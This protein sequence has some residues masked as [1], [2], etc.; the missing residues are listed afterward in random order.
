VERAEFTEII[1]EDE[2]ASMEEQRETDSVP[3]VDEIRY[4]ITGNV[5]TYGAISEA[6][7]K[8]EALEK[9]LCSINIYC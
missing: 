4:H 9:L 5:Q 8:V 6:S 2:A 3:L 1:K 7:Q